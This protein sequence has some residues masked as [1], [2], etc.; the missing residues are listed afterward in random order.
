MK[1]SN[2]IIINFTLLLIFITIYL[3]SL[4]NIIFINAIPFK[5]I[6]VLLI[7]FLFIIF[8]LLF[9]IKNVLNIPFII[10]NIALVLFFYNCIESS[11]KFISSF[12]SKNKQ[13]KI[14]SLIVLKD[15]QIKNMEDLNGKILSNYTNQK[16]N[17]TKVLTE[18]SNEIDYNYIETPDMDTA[19]K[20]V[21][22]KEADFIILNEILEDKISFEY[23]VIKKFSFEEKITKKKK[24]NYQ[25]D[26]SYNFLISGLDTFGDISN[27][28]RSDVNILLTVN[29]KMNK[30]LLTS[31]PRDYYVHIYNTSGYND[32]LAHAGIY[33]IDV[34][35]KTIEEILNTK[36]D[37]Y[38]KINFSTL[39]NLIDSIGGID[40]YSELNFNSTYNKNNLFFKQGY[41]HLDGQ[42]ALVFSRERK[43]FV[44]GDIQRIKNQQNVIASIINKLSSSKI[45]ITKYNKI[46]KSL[47][48]TF[49]SNIEQELIYEFINKQL[50]T[51]PI[52]S[53][54]SYTLNGV[55]KYDYTYTYNNQLLYVMVPNSNE[56]LEAQKRIKNIY[57]NRK[58]NISLF[59][60]NSL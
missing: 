7:Y 45:L 44:D 48:N 31:I 17:Y 30:I 55:A 32:K 43:T 36:I 4:Y 29:P 59:D 2:I 20:K 28:A 18:L 46:L 16:D 22:N 51:M 3:F 35:M 57:V 41:N 37:Y 27:V 38:M 21:E 53:I 14:F 33:G 9:K 34:T 60:I 10:F 39:I 47:V 13:T 11:T 25:M 8:I 52:W 1:K 56:V 12:S 26:K 49:D 40:T 42:S 19:I 58:W 24:E 50:D 5:Y 6:I 15:S 23:K 54:E